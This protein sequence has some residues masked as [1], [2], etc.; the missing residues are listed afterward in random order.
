AAGDLHALD[1]DAAVDLHEA[2]DVLAQVDAGETVLLLGLGVG[3]REV[4]RLLVVALDAS[5]ERDRLGWL[6][7][8]RDDRGSAENDRERNPCGIHMCSL[9][10][11]AAH[12]L[13]ELN[14]GKIFE[15][16]S[17]NRSSFARRPAR[18]GD[19]GTAWRPGGLVGA[20]RVAPAARERRSPE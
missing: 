6:G 16:A 11:N 19:R 8:L 3:Q 18:A 12:R 10:H 9:A 14:R 4:L 5:V 7:G 2:S 15:L 13:V 1:D 20:A 17:E